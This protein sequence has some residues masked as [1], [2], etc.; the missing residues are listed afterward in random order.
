MARRKVRTAVKRCDDC[1]PEAAAHI[2]G[3]LR[4]ELEARG[5]MIGDND[6]WIA[7]HAITAQ[8]VLVSNDQN[9]FR[10]VPGLKLQN[11]A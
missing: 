2:Y 5:E 7:A 1:R 8:L 6:L 3:K 11:W 9:E 4:S 10:R